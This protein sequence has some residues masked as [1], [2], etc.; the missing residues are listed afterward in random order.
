MIHDDFPV[1]RMKDDKPIEANDHVTIDRENNL[2]SLMINNTEL[3]DA[4]TYECIITNTA[5]SNKCSAQLI[6]ESES[7]SFRFIHFYA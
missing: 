2:F 7:L 1:F 5:G 4:G 6:I 3:E